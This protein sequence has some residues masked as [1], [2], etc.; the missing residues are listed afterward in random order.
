MC[1]ETAQDVDTLA[2]AIRIRGGA[3][4]AGPSDDGARRVVDLV[5]PDGL[6]ITISSE[7]RK[8]SPGA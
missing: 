1:I 2:K 7:V 6:R 4:A 8:A 3:I 5:D